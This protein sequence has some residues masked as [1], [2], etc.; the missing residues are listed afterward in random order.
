MMRIGSRRGNAMVELALSVS[1]ILPLFLGTFQF[2]YTFYVYNML[3]T[4]VR[5]GARYAS[6]RQFKAQNAAS[7]SAYKLAVRNMVRYSTPDG[8][9]QLIVPSLDDAD[10]I[11]KIL[12]KDGHDADS[13]HAPATVSLTINDYA[14]NAAVATVTFNQKPYLEFP[15][16]GRYA[17]TE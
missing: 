13:T 1:V 6:L 14:L 4:Q 7:I 16:V 3:L 5:G 9:G 15:Y 10:V 12:D 11:V 17:P 8:I 2:G